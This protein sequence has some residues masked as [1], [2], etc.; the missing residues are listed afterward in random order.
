VPAQAG[1]FKVTFIQLQTT[2]PTTVVMPKLAATVMISGLVPV[3]PVR[4]LEL[5]TVTPVAGHGGRITPEQDQVSMLSTT[6][7]LCSTRS[8]LIGGGLGSVCSV[9]AAEFVTT[10]S[11]RS[12]A[13]LEGSTLR[14]PRV[15]SSR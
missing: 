4:S 15:S 9:A 8:N 3:A 10:H 13:L 6:D 12:L 7:S 14:T 1:I 5:A 11:K 2:I